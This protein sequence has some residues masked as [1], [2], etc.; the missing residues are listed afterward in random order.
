M[1][2]LFILP[3]GQSK[4]VNIC[5]GLKGSAVKKHPFKVSVSIDLSENQLLI[6]VL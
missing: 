5:C 1:D 6:P 4:K 3:L 2:S